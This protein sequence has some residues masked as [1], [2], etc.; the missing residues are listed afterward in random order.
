ML[1]STTLP[2]GWQ[3]VGVAVRERDAVRLEVLEGP[4]R[5]SYY[6][7]A[8][9]VADALD[10]EIVPVYRLRTRGGEAVPIEAGHVRTSSTGRML[11]VQLDEAHAIVQVPAIALRAHYEAGAGRPTRIVIPPAPVS[12][13]ARALGGNALAVAS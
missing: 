5:G 6:V 7:G 1:A 3:P 12:G 11:V 8:E 10:G 9:D 2:N 13:A 4:A